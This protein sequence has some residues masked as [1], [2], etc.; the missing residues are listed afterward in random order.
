[1]NTKISTMNTVRKLNTVCR[2]F[3]VKPILVALFVVIAASEQA[4]ATEP[5]L[6]FIE[7]LRNRGY[8]DMALEY[9]ADLANDSDAPADVK[10]QIPYQRGITQLRQAETMKN[11]DRQRELLDEATASLAAFV[12]AAPKD[13]PLSADANTQQGNVW[14]SRA[15]VEIWEASAP[16]NEGAEAPFQKRARDYI[17]KARKI[18]Q[19]AHDQ[20]EAKYKSYPTFIPAEEQDLRDERDK[21]MQRF[22][23]AQ[24][25][26]AKCTYERAQSFG[27]DS[28]LRTKTLTEA[29]E[30][31][32]EIHERYR[33][34]FSGLY[35]RLYQGK[36][37]EEQGDIRKALGLYNEVLEHRGSR[38]NTNLAKLQDIARRFRM[39][40]LNHPDRKDY[41]LVVDEGT[42]WKRDNSARISSQTGLGILF[43]LARGYENLAENRAAEQAMRDNYLK[44]SLA[45]ARQINRYPGELKGL[46]ATMIQRLMVKLD[47]D[48]SDPKDFDTAYGLANTFLDEIAAKKAD[49]EAAQASGNKEKIAEAQEA[50]QASAT[51][52][53]RLY[54][55]ALKLATPFTDPNLVNFA[56]YRLSYAYLLEGKYLESAVMGSYIANNYWDL[57][58]ATAS[59][60]AYLALAGLDREY[61]NS[62]KGQRDFE[63]QQVEKLANRII[64]DFPD[65]GRANDARVA[66]ARLYRADGKQLQAAERY[67]E[68]PSTAPQ[69]AQAQID[70]GQSYWN[71]YLTRAALP[72]G[73]RPPAE[74]LQKFRV[75]AENHLQ[76]GVNET[77]KKLTPEAA[78]P[79]ELTLAK[80]SLT[81]IRN[82]DGVYKTANG[83]KGSIDLLTGAPHSVVKAVAVPEGEKR[84]TGEGEVKG[85]GIASLV[86][87][88]LL[89]A[90]I[91]VRD[92]EKARQA[93]G[94]LEAV[95]GKDD[96]A[97]LT[98]IYI[99]FGRELQTELATLKA[100]GEDERLQSVRSA[101][102]EFLDDLFK[103]KDGQTFNSLLWIAE[104]YGG[105]GEGSEDQ[106]SVAKTY[107]D[108]A[109][110]AYNKIVESAGQP[111]FPSEPAQ[112]TGVR[113]RLA[114]SRRRQG[115]FEAAE[116]TMLEV[117]AE[118]P[119][120]LD[121]QYEA[122]LIYESWGDAAGDDAKE[123]Y[124]LAIKGRDEPVVVWGYNR[125]AQR[126]RSASLSEP[127]NE[128]Y[129]K[130]HFDAN[131]HVAEVLKKL[132]GNQS[133]EERTES[134]ERAK[135]AITYLTTF[136]N[137][138]PDDEYP[139]FNALYREI[140][141]ELGE[142]IEDLHKGS[143]DANTLA[144]APEEESGAADTAT[145]PAA[146]TAEGEPEGASINFVPILA[147]LILAGL[148]GGGLVALQGSQKKKR[149][150]KFE[151]MKSKPAATKKKVRK[152]PPTKT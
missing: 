108:K 132:A 41:Q 24:L 22:I 96:A 33:T 20:Y 57:D 14:L 29:S 43:E 119:R 8:S 129:R 39:I 46:S 149:R 139:R 140:Q 104:T 69:Y 97:E 150:A 112:I 31:F 72:E 105:L 125:L 42:E 71:V 73:E 115:D 83:K 25:N 58:K 16:A 77:E 99:E 27:E 11:R 142:P 63:L 79:R 61:F 30:Q 123:K 152:A 124:M 13:H 145:D 120:A 66:V 131:Y 44:Q 106:P 47:R 76:T 82:A 127:K 17:E 133:G 15:Q 128:D 67:S 90:Y 113:V 54:Q 74:E 92:L 40:C 116:K 49:L 51:E 98:R 91:G 144:L 110:S 111:N 26:L 7:G 53:S 81:Q 130:Q 100:A 122:A 38:Q 75:A 4:R 101:F 28:E 6:E 3:S 121:A 2:V 45:L 86:Y 78:T 126:L 64:K 107:F 103:R 134:L 89:R 21:A 143:A 65:D 85:K 36:C 95:A 56:R 151:A 10:I 102:E 35:A 55:I 118:V 48:P 9:L 70:A 62:P 147:V 135:V 18:F 114:N 117:L 68:V 59:E 136:A 84:P 138:F 32:R 34:Y 60:A 146:P 80:L 23:Q 19:Q 141:S 148:I 12:K 93:R 94:D 109:A 137:E 1:M 50:V 88:Q 87:Q 52:A 37:F 5:Y